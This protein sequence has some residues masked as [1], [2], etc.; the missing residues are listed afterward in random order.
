[1]PCPTSPVSRR[2]LL[3]QQHSQ[4]TDN[5]NWTSTSHPHRQQ[6]HIWCLWMGF[7][8]Y[9][10]KQL[11]NTRIMKIKFKNVSAAML[12]MRHYI[13]WGKQIAFDSLV[14]SNNSFWVRLGFSCEFSIWLASCCSL[15]IGLAVYN[16]LYQCYRVFLPIRGSQLMN[17][18]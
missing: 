12:S 14:V 4:T 3:H 5:F 17:Y 7:N 2:Y 6:H 1:M 18:R 15:V 16:F 11:P 13:I 10:V 8:K 9:H